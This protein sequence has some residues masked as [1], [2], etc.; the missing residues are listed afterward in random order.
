[1]EHIDDVETVKKILRFFRSKRNLTSKEVDHEVAEMRI[2]RYDYSHLP[3]RLFPN[4][5]RTNK[6]RLNEEMYNLDEVESMLGSLSDTL[7]AT[8]RQHMERTAFMAVLLVRQLLEGGA[9][10]DVD[11]LSSIHLPQLEDQKALSEIAR[12]R[13]D[14]P[15]AE[16]ARAKRKLKSVKDEN[17]RLHDKVS[18]L[19]RDRS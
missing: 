19:S 1:M 11:L 6:N 4:D 16:K 15:P 13:I 2:S 5:A 18:D 10:N 7:Q 3:F 8:V 14:A 9:A 12:I 17:V